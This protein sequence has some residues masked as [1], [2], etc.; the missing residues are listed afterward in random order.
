MDLEK[1]LINERKQLQQRDFNVQEV[2]RRN[3]DMEAEV[4]RQKLRI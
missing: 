4:E 3:L 2:E 1:V